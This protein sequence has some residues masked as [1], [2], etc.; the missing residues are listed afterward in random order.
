MK[1]DQ[2]SQLLIYLTIAI[3][4]VTSIYVFYPGRLFIETY[5]IWI[6]ILWILVVSVFAVSIRIIIDEKK[7]NKT[8]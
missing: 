3:V 1:L 2:K 5:Y 4:L 8:K 6:T 7:K